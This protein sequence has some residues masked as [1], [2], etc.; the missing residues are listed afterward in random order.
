M[1]NLR[2]ATAVGLAL[3]V[4][5]SISPAYAF[6]KFRPIVPTKDQY[7]TKSLENHIIKTDCALASYDHL[8]YVEILIKRANPHNM[9][10]NIKYYRWIVKNGAGSYKRQDDPPGD[11]PDVK[12]KSRIDLDLYRIIANNNTPVRIDVIV[13]NEKLRFYKDDTAPGMAVTSG[14]ENGDAI[15]CIK[16]SQ[17]TDPA[18]PPSGQNRQVAQ[19]YVIYQS[20]ARVGTFNIALVTSDDFNSDYSTIIVIDP[21]IRNDG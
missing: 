4:S 10:R 16:G 14:D 17:P 3:F 6:D 21:K 11:I 19:F 7:R 2:R 5:G 9:V 8:S 13:D 18:D 12:H 15:F 1:S 20:P